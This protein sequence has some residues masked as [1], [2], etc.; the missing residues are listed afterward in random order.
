MITPI[1][2]PRCQTNFSADIH[3]IIDVGRTPQLKFDLLNGQLN[4]FTCPRCGTSGQLATPLLYHDPNH[5]LFMVYVPMELR[6][7]HVEQEKLIGQLV[8]HLMDS[9]PPEERRGYMLNPQTIINFQTFLEKVL[10]TEGITPDMIARQRKQGELLQTLVKADQEVVDIL[11]KERAGEIDETFFAMLQQLM[12]AAQQ[13]QGNPDQL[14]KITNLRARL[15]TTTET[16]RRLEKRETALRAFQR[17]ARKQNQIT[18][19]LLLKHVLINKEDV[20]TATSLIMAGQ[21]AFNYDFFALLSNEIENQARTHNKQEVKQLTQLREVLL[22]TQKM[23]QEQSQQVMNEFQN[24]LQTLLEAPDKVQAIQEHAVEI[25]E[26]FMYLLTSFIEQAKA[27]GQQMEAATLEH[28][29][30][31]ILQEAE[32]QVPPEIRLINQLVRASSEE[33]QRRILA[34]NKPLVTVDFAKMLTALIKEMSPD[35]AATREQLN[36][37]KRLVEATF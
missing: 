5:S 26:T 16:G 31:L 2:C 35:Q 14:V 23:L 20:T 11:L 19:A 24:T 10:E 21:A 28:I 22:E 33:E 32:N 8:K 36:R 4:V 13:Q 12:E 34:E 37:I 7:P 29:Y 25:D 6:L 15:Y 18:P 30:H 17:E 1:T 3:Q 9:L 27:N